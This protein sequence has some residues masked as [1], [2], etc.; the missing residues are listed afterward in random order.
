MTRMMCKFCASIF[1]LKD[2]SHPMDE[3]NK[4]GLL[5]DWVWVADECPKCKRGFD[6]W[7]ESEDR[8]HGGWPDLWRRAVRY[9]R[10]VRE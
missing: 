4:N 1:D 7:Y 9:C 6:D 10:M 3:W 5:R 8:R 2:I